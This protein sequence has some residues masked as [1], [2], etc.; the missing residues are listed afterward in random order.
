MPSGR[1]ATAQVQKTHC[2][3][4]YLRV[5]S[6]C[7]QAVPRTSVFHRLVDVLEKAAL[8]RSGTPR[9]VTLLSTKNLS[10]G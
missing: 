4:R 1:K 10:K 8:H 9:H 6:S 7:G 3:L 2:C 5:H